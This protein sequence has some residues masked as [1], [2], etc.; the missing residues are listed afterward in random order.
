LYYSYQL[1]ILIQQLLDINEE[2]NNTVNKSN[3]KY[4][5]NLDQIN[6]RGESLQK[7]YVVLT[8]EREHINLMIREFETL[9]QAEQNSDVNVTM[10][11]YNY[12]VLLFVTILLILLLLR[13]SVSSEQTGGGRNAVSNIFKNL[14]SK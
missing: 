1:Q 13:F 4:Q 12:I 14:F 11:Y 2:I 8:D 5:N 9:N 10:N 7:N 3:T 6:Q